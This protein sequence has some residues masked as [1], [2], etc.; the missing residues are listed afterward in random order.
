[1][2][3]TFG[4]I[5]CVVAV[6]TAALFIGAGIDNVLGGPQRRGYCTR[7]CEPEQ[8]VHVDEKECICTT[9]RIPR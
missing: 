4:I 8:V 9:K 2:K 7:A 3:E 5:L 6:G 1:M